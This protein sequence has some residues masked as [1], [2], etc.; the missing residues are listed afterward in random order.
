MHGGFVQSLRT[1]K[2]FR[3]RYASVQVRNEQARAIVVRK[4]FRR[5]N[6]FRRRLRSGVA[7]V[8]RGVAARCVAV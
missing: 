7:R 6:C 2:A 4:T 5:R 1:C 8:S 3:K